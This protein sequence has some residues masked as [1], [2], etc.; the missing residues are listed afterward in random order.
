MHELKLKYKCL[1]KTEM[2]GSFVTVHCIKSSET[3]DQ[4]KRVFNT[5]LGKRF[6]QGMHN[7]RR[8]KLNKKN[9]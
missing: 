7:W 2:Y 3:N 8:D 1:L 9:K 4:A 6:T 5:D